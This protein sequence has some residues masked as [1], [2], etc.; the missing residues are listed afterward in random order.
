M[1]IITGSDTTTYSRF[2]T[3]EPLNN[4]IKNWTGIWD[5]KIG[6]L[7]HGDPYAVISL[8]AVAYS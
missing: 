6:F 4:H 7:S 1:M 8:E 2:L 5:E 3:T